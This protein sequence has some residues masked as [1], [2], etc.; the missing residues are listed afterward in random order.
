M[1]PGWHLRRGWE[2]VPGSRTK[3]ILKE[4]G[5]STKTGAWGSNPALP[6]QVRGCATPNLGCRRVKISFQQHLLGIKSGEM[7]KSAAGGQGCISTDVSPSTS[8]APARFT[9]LCRGRRIQP[10]PYGTNQKKLPLFPQRM[11]EASVGLGRC[12]RRIPHRPELHGR[13]PGLSWK[14]DLGE[15]KSQAEASPRRDATRNNGFCISGSP[16]KTG[17]LPRSPSKYPATESR[18]KPYRR[19]GFWWLHRKH[20]RGGREAATLVSGASERLAKP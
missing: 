18:T 1:Q 7:Q 12:C 11:Q 8:R 9:S 15:P 14:E 6:P 5:L 19:G 2:T 16:S 4:T 13:A 20:L 10:N 17:N 3:K